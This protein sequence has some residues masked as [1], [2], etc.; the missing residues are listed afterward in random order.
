MPTF[1]HLLKKNCICVPGPELEKFEIRLE[2]DTVCPGRENWQTM[3]KEKLLKNDP[4]AV[5]LSVMGKALWLA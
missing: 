1:M 5:S 2:R 4:T 3:E